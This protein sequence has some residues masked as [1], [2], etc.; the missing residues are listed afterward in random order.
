MRQDL[1]MTGYMGLSGTDQ[2]IAM[3]RTRLSRRLTM[4][5]LDQAVRQ[6]RRQQEYGSRAREIILFVP[7]DPEGSTGGFPRRRQAAGGDR[8][9]GGSC[10]EADR[11]AGVS[12]DENGIAA[13]GL[14]G[15]WEIRQEGLLQSLW[16][17]SRSW[18]TG[19]TV[20]LRDVPVRQETIEVCEILE[21]NPYELES[22]GC[23]WIAADHGHRL[24]EELKKE[25]IPAAVV[26]ELTDSSD[27]LLV[28]DD[29]VSYLN[30][31]QEEAYSRYRRMVDG[32]KQQPD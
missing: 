13:C 3:E 6:Y 4:D 32:Q 25:G 31:P 10:R 27:C 11:M 18:G 17:L 19:F 2:L 29:T 14:A 30:R 15:I 9:Q 16:G 26:G 5:F 1:I 28:H 21:I 22:D 7:G 8:R 24:C 23:L 12:R 20:R